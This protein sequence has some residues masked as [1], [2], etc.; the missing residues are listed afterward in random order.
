MYYPIVCRGSLLT[1]QTLTALWQKCNFTEHR[2]HLLTYVNR[3]L[4]VW[5]HIVATLTN[6]VPFSVK[7]PSCQL[8]GQNVSARLHVYLGLTLLHG[9]PNTSRLQDVYCTVP[10]QRP[11]TLST[12]TLR[13]PANSTPSWAPHSVILVV[14]YR[15]SMLRD[16]HTH[17]QPAMVSLASCSC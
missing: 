12:H 10:F 11:P 13:S 16:T 9:F 7:F 1:C 6:F 4:A 17:T 2:W 3:G 5:R 8:S 15:R 14:E